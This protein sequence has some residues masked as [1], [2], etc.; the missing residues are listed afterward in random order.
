MDRF[1][2][3]FDIHM[4]IMLMCNRYDDVKNGYAIQ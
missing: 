4:Y 2:R 1:L 3:F